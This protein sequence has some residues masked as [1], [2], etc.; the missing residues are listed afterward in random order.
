MRDAS[1]GSIDGKKYFQITI[2][3]TLKSNTPYSMWHDKMKKLGLS[4]FRFLEWQVFDPKLFDKDKP[5]IEQNLTP[6]VEWH[7][8]EDLNNKQAEDLNTFLE[9]YMAVRVPADSLFYNLVDVMAVVDSEKDSSEKPIPGAIY[10]IGVDVASVHDYFVIS[11]FQKINKHMKQR[12]LFYINKIELP[13][14]QNKVESIIEL[15]NPVK[16]RIDT[17]GVGLQLTQYCQGVFGHNI[18][19]GVFGGTS[20]KGLN[21]KHRVTLKE[22]IHTNQKAMIL[23]NQVTLLNDELQLRHYGQWKHDFTADSNAE[24][25]HGDTVV[26]N[27]YALLEDN[28]RLAKIDVDDTP[29]EKAEDITDADAQTKVRE[30]NKSGYLNKM[31]FYGKAKVYI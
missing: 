11:I 1:R 4:T 20:I 23:R 30:F 18:V 3:S 21:K 9:E 5:V 12:Y 14:A 7:E 8:I 28:W 25:G 15:F 27:G 6:I 2:G 31:K 19:E 22:F 16:A 13:A 10:Y 17:V 24:I 29:V 26:A